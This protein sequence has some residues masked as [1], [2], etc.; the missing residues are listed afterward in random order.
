MPVR[1][2][3]GDEFTVTTD[4]S[5]FISPPHNV[6]NKQEYRLGP[7]NLCIIILISNLLVNSN[8]SAYYSTFNDSNPD[9]K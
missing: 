8:S 4:Q 7:G 5:Y 6:H 9:M 3:G 1:G 2:A